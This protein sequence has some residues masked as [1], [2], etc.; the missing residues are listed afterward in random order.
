MGVVARVTAVDQIGVP[1]RHSGMVAI[2]VDDEIMARRIVAAL[3]RGGFDAAPAGSAQPV[4]HAAVVIIGRPDGVSV[5]EIERV[6]AGNED[7][8]VVI[9]IS[10][11]DEHAAAAALAAGADGIVVDAE[12]E[13][14][15]AATV[16]CVLVGQTV[17]PRF[18]R[19]PDR[20]PILSGREKQVLGMVVLGCSNGE[21]AARL[22]VAESTVKSHLTSIFSK[23]QVRSRSEAAARVL[24]PTSGLGLGVVSIAEHDPDLHL[25]IDG[26]DPG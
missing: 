6:R 1:S 8:R 19:A 15:V 23:L 7:V 9:V 24:D 10:E 22:H 26:V 3:V 17:A 2:A 20:G 12:L 13:R 25:T 5:M 11:T 18:A 4:P 16:G 21:I 14:S